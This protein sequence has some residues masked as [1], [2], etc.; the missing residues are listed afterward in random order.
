M[1]EM[2]LRDKIAGALYGMALGDAMGMPAELW[3]RERARKFFGGEITGF[4]NGPKENDV[5]SAI[6]N[7][8][9][10]LV[11]SDILSVEE[12]GY[13][14]GCETF[15]PRLAECVKVGIQIAKEY[16]GNDA[17]FLK[18]VYDVIGAGVGIIESVPAAES[19][20]K[21]EWFDQI[22]MSRYDNIY[23][24]GYQVCG[25]SGRVITDWLNN[26]P[27]VWKKMI[28]LQGDSSALLIII[29]KTINFINSTYGFLNWRKIAKETA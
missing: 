17:A 7:D 26:V 28:F 19:H 16:A 13:K 21:K 5:A 12:A 14:R 3:G 20:F 9:F 25:A 22:D 2:E 1:E 8:D 6:V 15:S 11:L 27:D 4:L 10:E 18:K 23:I 24:A 29:M